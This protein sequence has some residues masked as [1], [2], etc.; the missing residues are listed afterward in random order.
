MSTITYSGNPAAGAAFQWSFG[1]ASSVIGS[2]GPYQ[3]GWNIPGLK[4]FR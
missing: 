4:R 2:V 1:N 3:A